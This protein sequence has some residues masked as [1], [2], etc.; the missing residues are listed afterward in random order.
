MNVK[1]ALIIVR[2]LK[3]KEYSIKPYQPFGWSAVEMVPIKS[4]FEEINPDIFRPLKNN[5]K[6]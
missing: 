6:L 5:L 4:Q 3:N 1:N 2:K